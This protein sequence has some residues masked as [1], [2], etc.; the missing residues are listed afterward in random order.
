MDLRPYEISERDHRILNPFSPDR[1]RLLGEVS[2]V[3]PGT[4]ILDLACGKGELLCRWA[5]WFGSA[6]VGVDISPVFLADARARAAEL[7]VA[8]RV[9]FEEGDAGAYRAEPGAFD[10]A[11]CIGA[12]WIG[13][14][15]MGTSE[16][17]Q[18]S[19]APGGHILIGEPFWRGDPPPA[20][21]EALGLSPDD[22]TSLSG[23]VDRLEQSGLELIE[24]VLADETCWDRYE[25]PKWRAVDDWLAANATDPYAATMRT[26]LA[27]SR[28]AYLTWGRD[29]LG[30][31]VFVTRPS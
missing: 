5:E 6:G 29:L 28:R 8:E 20:A 14:G 15:L 10:I 16:L 23:T 21:V 30:W 7:R 13:G 26:F 17:L 11:A 18:R 27:E 19:L 1:L 9:T 24:M 25:A 3:G 12:T 2:R 22:L 31:G 4:R